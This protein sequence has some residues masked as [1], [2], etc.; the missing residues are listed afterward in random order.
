MP[1]QFIGHAAG[2]G[3]GFL[4]VLVENSLFCLIGFNFMLFCVPE[5]ASEKKI[6]WSSR[7]LK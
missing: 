6:L 4:F 3:S 2:L 7:A 1:G 5:L